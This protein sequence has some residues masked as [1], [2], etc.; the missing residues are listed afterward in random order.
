MGMTDKLNLTQVAKFRELFT[1]G[2]EK[3]RLACEVYV[4]A[5]TKNPA[6]EAEFRAAF[7]QISESGWANI[8]LVG[9]GAMDYRLLWE[10]GKARNRIKLLPPSRQAAVLDSGVELLA[11]DGSELKVKVEN[12]NPKQV[13]QVFGGDHIRT[14]PEQRAWIEA[15]ATPM[16]PVKAETVAEVKGKELVVSKPCR[17]SRR[18]LLMF[19]AQMEG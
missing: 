12:L 5:V 6:L 18:D 17:M 15:Q 11:K 10:G 13:E 1:G 8:E 9:R 16:P 4:Q 3:I 2:M 7:P 14:L 19:L